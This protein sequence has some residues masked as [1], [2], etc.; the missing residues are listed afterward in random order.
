MNIPFYQVRVQPFEPLDKLVYLGLNLLR[1]AT[2]QRV[3]D[4]S[5]DSYLNVV[6]A[7]LAIEP[8]TTPVA[9]TRHCR[10]SSQVASCYEA[11]TSL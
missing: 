11:K 9:R 7:V 3:R 1:R 6:C 8:Y 2:R 4:A 10:F 5:K